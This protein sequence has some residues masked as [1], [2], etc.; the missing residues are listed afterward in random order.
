MA[1][2]P[3]PLESRTADHPVEELFLKRWSPRAMTG[4]AVA[5][6]EL[7]RLF[8]AARWAP[9]T[10]NE[11]EWRFLY[12][13]RDGDHWQT[14]FD[15][16]V[17][18]NQ[19]WCRQAGVLVLAISKKTFTANGK[20]NPVHTLDCGMA[21]QNLLL[22]SA[23]MENVVTHAMAGFNRSQAQSAL[24][25]PDDYSV[26]C[27]IAIGRPGNPDELPEALRSREAVS[28]RKPITEFTAEGPFDFH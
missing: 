1:S 23:T 2:L 16:L 18:A 17:E 13:H 7:D 10:Y 20:P 6:E 28:D 11:Q 21:V 14:F 19:T 8:E 27:M 15:L 5:Q 9:S 22:Q 25:I 26:E 4:E 3:N 24:G 12:A